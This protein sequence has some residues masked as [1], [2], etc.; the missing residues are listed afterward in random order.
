MQQGRCAA[1]SFLRSAMVSSGLHFTRIFRPIRSLQ[2]TWHEQHIDQTPNN[3]SK[4]MLLCTNPSSMQICSKV[5]SYSIMLQAVPW[6]ASIM[7]EECAKGPS[8]CQCCEGSY[9]LEVQ[10]SLFLFSEQ[11]QFWEMSSTYPC[12]FYI[13]WCICSGTCP[14]KLGASV[15]ALNQHISKPCFS[16]MFL[17]RN[18]PN[19]LEPQHY[20]D[21]DPCCSVAKGS[22]GSA[23]HISPI[24]FSSPLLA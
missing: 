20:D 13:F 1:I 23:I 3:N 18:W 11:L 12:S 22:I 16:P 6:L 7:A 2:M 4:S 17:L 14:S 5:P 15:V 8:Y 10:A 9:K 24:F 21:N 19:G